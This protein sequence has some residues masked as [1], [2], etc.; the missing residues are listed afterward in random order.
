MANDPHRSIQIP[1][2]RYWVH[3]NAPGWH[4][5]GGGEPVLPGVSIGHNDYGAWGLTIFAIDQED[6]YVYDTDPQNPDLYRYRDG[7]EE[8]TI[9]RETI[10]V[11]GEEPVT[12]ELKYTRHG[13]VLHEDREHNKS[14]ALRAAWLEV[15]GAPYLASLRMDQAKNWQ[16]FRE[17]CRFSHTPS[18]NMVWA[19]RENDIGWQAV[20][21]TPIRNGWKGLL[22]VPGDGRYE[23]KDYLPI[24]DLPH[25]FNPSAG[26]FATANQNNV[27][28]GYPHDLGFL[29]S[30]PYRFLRI[31]EVLEAGDSFSLEDMKKLQQDYLSIPAR[32][33]VPY[34]EDLHSSD[35]RVEKAID[36]LTNWDYVMSEKSVEAT[37]YS[38]WFLRLR[39]NVWDLLM[40]GSDLSRP[41]RR[42]MRILMDALA[43]PD[44]KFGSEPES[45]RDA[46]LIESLEQ[47]VVDLEERLG[48]D[49]NLWE[50][51]QEK[52]H[53]IKL[54]H[55]MSRV[56]NDDL[57]AQLDIG[58]LP[59]GGDGFTV[60]MTG[61]G[62][63]QRSGGSFRIIADCSDWDN[64]VGTNCPGQSGDPENPHYKD[65]IGPWA[66]GQ[67]F[68]IYF[69]RQKVLSA[70]ESIVVLEPIK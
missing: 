24:Q 1:S 4:V 42:P 22:P 15:G 12:V 51:G 65:L 44:K 7:W 40:K 16:E 26:F 17:A 3:L 38:G 57:R 43:H 6:L 9:L 10:P 20:G 66:V 58:P 21:I 49:W 46:L 56:V 62:Y 2:L 29:W 14:Y 45:G 27:P 67:Y 47:A 60:N 23:W 52:F 18:E 32:E 5:I 37:I 39:E 13:P 68:P 31:E 69:S 63:N 48:S 11:K 54:L 50:Y 61:S 8:M 36:T 28:E 64:S 55:G 41:P 35:P 70:A 25:V 19:D 53:H 34:L 59:R 33:L 30:D